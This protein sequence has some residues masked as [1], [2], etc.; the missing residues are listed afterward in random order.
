MII[1]TLTTFVLLCKL[2]PVNALQIEVD[3]QEDN[4]EIGWKHKTFVGIKRAGHPTEIVGP[5]P[6]GRNVWQPEKDKPNEGKWVSLDKFPKIKQRILDLYDEY[7]AKLSMQIKECHEMLG[8]E[9]G[10]PQKLNEQLEHAIRKQLGHDSHS[11]SELHASQQH[12]HRQPSTGTDP[13]GRGDS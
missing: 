5:L 13:K 10:S 2:F 9:V 1:G 7:V 11:Q 3:G 12:P 6:K 8:E 4:Y